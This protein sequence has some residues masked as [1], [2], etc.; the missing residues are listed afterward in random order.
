[1]KT[2]KE[3]L[4]K[5]PCREACPA[6]IDIPRYLRYIA[7][8]HFNEAFNVIREKIPFPWVCGMVCTHPCELKCRLNDVD[9]PVAIRIL[10]RFVSEQPE[11][12]GLFPET[13]A[14]MP[15]RPVEA[16]AASTKPAT[17]I[18]SFCHL[19]LG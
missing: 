1:M 6:D 19:Y 10:K 15:L 3:A 11:H 8:G 7:Q 2:F 5:S 12:Y 13:Q 4:V 17:Q 14:I 18:R 9:E 16:A